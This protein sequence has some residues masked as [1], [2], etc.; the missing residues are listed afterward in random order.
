MTDYTLREM[1]TVAA[2]REIKDGDIV[3]CGT[4][5]S[6]VAAMAAK[7]ISAPRSIIFFETGG[8]DS[9]LRELPLSV[10]IVGGS[11]RSH[12]VAQVVMKVLNVESARELSEV[13]AAV[14]LAQNLA[15][16]RALATEGIQRGHMNLHARQV[17][18][19]AGA[20][21]TDVDRISAQLVIEGQIRVERA[22]E[23]LVSMGE[24]E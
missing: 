19:A 20:T 18:V 22:R 1:M 13:M 15:A 4:G 12:P 8:I 2:A 9:E 3:F 17:A 11:T 10:G 16:L 24:P 21:G 6:M 14:G 7:Q 23:L 5:I